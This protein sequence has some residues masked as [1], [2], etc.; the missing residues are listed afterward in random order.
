MSPR[1]IYLKID[2]QRER[3]LD[4]FKL[5]LRVGYENAH[6]QRVKKFPKWSKYIKG[7]K[8]DGKKMKEWFDDEIKKVEGG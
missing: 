1:E 3:S 2:G 6:L 4:R 7:Q 8:P 5:S